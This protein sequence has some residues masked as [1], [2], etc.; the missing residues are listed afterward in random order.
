MNSLEMEDDNSDQLKIL[1]NPIRQGIL[2]LV[3]EQGSISF[4]HLKEELQLTD[5][6]LFYHLKSLKQLLEKDRQ[7]FYKLSEKGKVVID[8]LIHK[9][10]IPEQKEEKK[11][12][13]LDKITFPDLFYYFFGD[14]VRSLIELNALLIVTAW[15][16]GV[17]NSY[18][19]SL[20]S[21][22]TGGAIVNSIISFSHWYLYL[23]LIYIALKILKVEFRVKELWIGVL[24]GI[25]PYFVYLIPT[26]I[27]HYTNTD[28]NNWIGIILTI[29][30]VICKIYSTLFVI[31]GINL[32]TKIERYQSVILACVLIFIDY[33]YLLITL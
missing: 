4:T 8:T 18:F 6:S 1:S 21:I 29:V 5:G 28:T 15:L 30:F 27:L 23:F 25:I 2:K 11:S 19:S 14:P 32:A 16:F 20:E 13:F 31:Q 17:S 10:K 24:V 33:I 12:W 7:N 3:S 9:V 26:G 22:M